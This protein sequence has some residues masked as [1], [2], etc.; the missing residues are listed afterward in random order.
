M[1]RNGHKF[2]AVRTEVDGL[3]FASKAEAKRYAELRLLE[4]AGEVSNLRLQPRYELL[5]D[6]AN[7]PQDGRGRQVQIGRY[8]A[9][10]AYVR[11]WNGRGKA[12]VEDVKGYDLPLAK[13]KRKHCEAQYGIQIM[14]IR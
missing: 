12:I 6:N 14:V 1:R 10:F 9:D 5:V 13:W 8:I 11:I 4:K 3:S 7:Y 2:N